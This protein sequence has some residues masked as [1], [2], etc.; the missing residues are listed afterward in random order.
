MMASNAELHSFI[1]ILQ[2]MDL[3]PGTAWTML[4]AVA[5]CH[6]LTVFKYKVIQ[7]ARAIFTD[8]R[9]KSSNCVHTNV[10]KIWISNNTVDTSQIAAR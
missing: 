4:T 7:I 5:K 9:M 1:F 10:G 3:S 6:M 8:R 2:F